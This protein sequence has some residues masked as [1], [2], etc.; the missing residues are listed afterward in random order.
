MLTLD[1]YHRHACKMKHNR[2]NNH[3]L[4]LR[5][6]ASTDCLKLLNETMKKENKNSLME[7]V[8]QKC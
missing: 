3:L 8:G 4:F 5:F 6:E 2:V 7:V 1:P